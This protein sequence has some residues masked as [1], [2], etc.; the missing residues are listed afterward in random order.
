MIVKSFVFWNIG[1]LCSLN[2]LTDLVDYTNPDFIII[3]E[4]CLP[5]NDILISINS[6]DYKKQYHFCT[7]NERNILIISKI[8]YINFEIIKSNSRYILP[9]KFKISSVEEILLIGVHLPSKLRTDTE[10]QYF[11]SRDIIKEIESIELT[12]KL[13]KTILV[14]DFNMNPFENG[15]VSIDGFNAVMSKNIARKE[16]K[17]FKGNIYKYLYNPMWGHF[18][19]ISTSP[20]GTYLFKNSD[21]KNKYYWNMFDQVLLRPK[22]LGNFDI[23]NLHIITKY[24]LTLHKSLL[25]VGKSVKILE[26]DHL[27]LYFILNF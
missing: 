21:Y 20:S 17:K 23:N 18:G 24:G 25:K 12:Y 10:E 22:L 5:I 11:T 6:L 15:M 7:K 13:D 27:P 8:S 4:N 26:N 9:I 16:T 14:G 1:N 19:D 2:I 3:A